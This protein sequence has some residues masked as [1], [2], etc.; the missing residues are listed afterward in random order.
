MIKF[1]QQNGIALIKLNRPEKRNAL[2]PIL[3]NEFKEKLNDIEND[4]SARILII[5]GE[6]SSFCSGADLDY[7]NQL[8]K[9]SAA[10]NEKD[11]KSIAELFLRLYH[12]PK[13]TIAAVNGPAIAGGCGLATVCD[14]IIADELNAK[15]GYTEVKIGFIPAVVS[16]FL[17]K[18]IGEGRTKQ[19]M[20]SGE[21]IDSWKAL[22]IGLANY[23]SKKVLDESLNLANR[24]M[25]NSDRSME[26]TK[27]MLNS[28]SLMN[29]DEAVE[30]CIELNI[31]S[32]SSED[33]LKGLMQFL[34]KK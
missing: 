33:F 15:F 5:T 12:F 4:K 34:N 21:L 32:R 6:G 18:K 9:F 22:E 8:R 16:I 25:E 17:I 26:M 23:L 27:K 20:I 10:D 31:I 28:I 19:L 2:H 14:F 7:L 1:E 3:I 29:A 30:Y 13:P 24:L 11:T